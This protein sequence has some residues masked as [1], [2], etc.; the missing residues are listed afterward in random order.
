MITS[1]EASDFYQYSGSMPVVDV[2]SPGEFAEG[3]IAGAINLPVFDDEE[4]AVVGTIYAKR[5]RSE[6]AVTGLDFV[7]PKIH[8]II[9]LA[10]KLAPHR[11]LILHCWRGGLRSATIATALDSAGFHVYLLTG[12]Y[13]AYRTCCRSLVSRSGKIM[14]LGGYTGSGKTELLRA[15]LQAGEQVIDL[16]NLAH[17]RGSAFG[18]LD[19]LSQPTNEQF[20]NDL[21][22]DWHEL[23]SNQV[24]WLEDESRMIGR[25]TLPEYLYTKIAT[26]PLIRIMVPLDIRIENL[27]R[28]Y[29]GTN[30]ELLA[31]AIQRVGQKMGGDRMQEAL[32]ALHCEDYCRVAELMLVYYDKAY[33]FSLSRR[34][35]QPRY[36]LAIEGKEITKNAVL[37]MNFA[38][39]II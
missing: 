23:L 36:S 28:E 15:M 21:F 25:V 22:S 29:A 17:H 33:E 16:E 1:L 35:D 39:N 37:L 20:E 12:G 7:L 19:G 27:V 2:R 10:K 8:E 6:A 34:P 4:R 5:G 31:G 13:K 14:V 11:K 32:K 24:V 26:S 38:K 18:A 3:H 9:R 30:H